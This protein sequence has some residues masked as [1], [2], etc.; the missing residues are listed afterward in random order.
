MT[1]RYAHLAPSHKVTAVDVRY[2]TFMGGL[3]K[4]SKK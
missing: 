3:M 1:L 2:D 4:K